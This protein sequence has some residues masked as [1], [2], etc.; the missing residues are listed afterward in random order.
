MDKLDTNMQMQT[1]ETTIGDLICAIRDAAQESM[2]EER[3]ISTLTH[4]ILMDILERRS[5]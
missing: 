2:I 5:H 3:D 4:V 1:I